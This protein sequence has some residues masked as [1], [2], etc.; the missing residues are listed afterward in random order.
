MKKTEG[1]SEIS[2]SLQQ[3]TEATSEV[4]PQVQVESRLGRFLRKVLRWITGLFVVFA[5]G[6]LTTYFVLYRPQVEQLNATQAELGKAQQQAKTF[7]S[8]IERLKP[9]EANSETLLEN[10]KKTEL[11]VQLLSALSDV[12]AARLALVNNDAPS[13]RV[14]LTDTLSTLKNLE[15]LVEQ[16]HRDLV[17]AMQNRLTLAMDEMKA[18][19]FASQ[20]DLAV[21][22]ANLVQL[23]NSYFAKP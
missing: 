16:D 1:N 2:Q 10:M 19:P 9:I 7:E 21:L 18:D 3:A 13:A 14:G 22:A 23:E 17:I 15:Q 12:N 6:V 4:T 8:E 5:G 11:H 20:S